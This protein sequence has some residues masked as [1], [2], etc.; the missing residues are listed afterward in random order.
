MLEAV[1]EI[2]AVPGTSP[3]HRLWAGTKLLVI[4]VLGAGLGFAGQMWGF[5]VVA[6]VIAIAAASARLSPVLLWRGF[7]PLMLA[8][9]LGA[10]LLMFSS[11]GHAVL[12]IGPGVITDKGIEH[13]I[14]FPGMLLLLALAANV[15][16]RTTPPA[17]SVAALGVLLHPLRRLRLPV[18]ELLTMVA[19]SLR[20]LPILAEEVTRLRQA[21]AT[22]GL[23]LAQGDVDSRMRAVEGWIVSLVRGNLRRAAELGEA[24]DA[25][26]YGDPEEREFPLRRPKIGLLDV[27]VLLASGALAVTMIAIR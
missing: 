17:E 4:L 3:V 14:R 11:T 2:S 22:R 26:G 8:L 12:R 9:L 24:M 10:L 27:V 19:I 25:R 16:N 7:R 5:A 21:Q 15:L 1:L 20:F 18:D 23:S 13:A 6:A